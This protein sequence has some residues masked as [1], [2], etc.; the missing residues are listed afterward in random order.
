MHS[1][2]VVHGDIKAVPSSLLVQG[3][4]NDPSQMNVL[5]DHDHSARLADFGLASALNNATTAMTNV[6]GGGREGTARSVTRRICPVP[7]A[8]T[9]RIQ[10]HGPRTV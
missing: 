10:V 9:L 3:R 2:G 6:L 5:V 1:L 8:K 7:I 4:D